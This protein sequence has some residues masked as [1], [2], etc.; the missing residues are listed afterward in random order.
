MNEYASNLD[1]KEPCHCVVKLNSLFQSGDGSF[2]VLGVANHMMVL[3]WMILS[4][5]F[6]DDDQIYHQTLEESDLIKQ[7]RG[8]FEL[9]LTDIIILF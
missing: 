1:E 4:S 8:D 6:N 5:G 7:S 2:L 3:Q 9:F